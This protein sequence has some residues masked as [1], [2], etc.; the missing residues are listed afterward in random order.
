MGAEVTALPADRGQYTTGGCGGLLPAVMK[1][2]TYCSSITSR[3][4]IISIFVPFR[5]TA[6]NVSSVLELRVMKLDGSVTGSELQGIGGHVHARQNQR[7]EHKS[8]R[9]IILGMVIVQRAC[10]Q[11]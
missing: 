6:S 8:Q 3:S 4:G 10:Q 11:R 5:A 9:R 1:Y 2:T 7:S